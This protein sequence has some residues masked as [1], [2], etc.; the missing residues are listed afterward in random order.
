MLMSKA[1]LAPVRPDVREPER[2]AGGHGKREGGA[3]DL[4]AA[5]AVT[6]VN[7]DGLAPA[8]A[9]PA[10]RELGRRLR[11]PRRCKDARFS[12]LHLK[13]LITSPT[14]HLGRFASAS[15]S[16]VLLHAAPW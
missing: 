15:S 8:H 7:E 14:D 16:F 3:N 9:V 13:G 5:L 6:P 4:P 1:R 11:P 12:M 10:P 2:S